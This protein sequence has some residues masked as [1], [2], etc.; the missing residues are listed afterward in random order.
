M[1]EDLSNLMRAANSGDA[2]SYRV[3]L[4]ALAARLRGTVRSKLAHMNK[5]PQDVEDI[6]QETLLAIHLK[7]HTWD[8]TAP[9]EPWVRAIAH[10]K[11]IDAL[12]R[13][14]FREHVNIDDIADELRTAPTSDPSASSDCARLLKT[15][16]ARQRRIIEAI[17]IEGRSAREVAEVFGSTEGAIRVALHRSLKAL[18]RAF[19]EVRR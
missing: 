17:A 12:R 18:A 13:R 15:L 9:L 1:P 10:H 7:R 3:L 19:R 4:T 14:G 8:E 5:D 6:V 11:M 16:P 2:D